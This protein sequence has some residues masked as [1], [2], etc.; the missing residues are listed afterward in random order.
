MGFGGELNDTSCIL[1]ED[2]GFIS[3]HIGDVENVETRNFL[4]EATEHLLRLINGKAEVLACDLHP[5]F[6]TTV[7]AKEWAETQRLAYGSGSAPSC[8]R[9]GFDG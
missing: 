2:K 1:L 4:D 6:T 8:P 5:K 9:R 3:Q 7:L